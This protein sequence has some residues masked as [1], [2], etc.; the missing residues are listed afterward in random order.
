MDE[1]NF[2]DLRQGIN[3]SSISGYYFKYERE[4]T[5]LEIVEKNGSIHNYYLKRGLENTLKEKFF[6]CI[7]NSANKKHAFINF[8][9]DRFDIYDIKSKS[10]KNN[11]NNNRLINKM[12]YNKCNELKYERQ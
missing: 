4:R 11:K 5:I 2:N 6:K 8:F 9:Q 3:I 10:S 7:E 12:L 1:I